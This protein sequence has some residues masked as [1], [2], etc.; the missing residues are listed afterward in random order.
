MNIVE[1]ISLWYGGTSFGYMPKS[2]TAVSSLWIKER[3]YPE[4]S[5]RVQSREKRERL[6]TARG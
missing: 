6:D 2:G 5:G 4:V 3:K 1:H